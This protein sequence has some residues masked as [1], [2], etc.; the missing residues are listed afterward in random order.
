MT[1]TY[2]DK[3]MENKEFKR[4]FNIEYK[5]LCDNEKLLEMLDSPDEQERNEADAILLR[6]LLYYEG[7]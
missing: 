3:L 4:K 2:L 7:D 5:E 1:K 6:R